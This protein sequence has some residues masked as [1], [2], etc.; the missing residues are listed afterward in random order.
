MT[1]T[2]T[3]T[4]A[5]PATRGSAGRRAVTLLAAPA[6]ALAIWVVSVPIAGL[7]LTVGSGS[8]ALTVHAGS[9]AAVALLMGAAAWALLAFLERLGRG[10]VRAWRITAWAVLA[11]SLLGPVSM[12]A[13]VAVL[14]SLLAMHVAVGLTVI[15][16]L[17]PAR[18]R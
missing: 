14:A 1:Q 5:D 15:L 17:A 6:V 10:G 9:V 13:S 4:S 7:D 2:Q 3:L 8:S 12:G 18:F 16:G 11:L